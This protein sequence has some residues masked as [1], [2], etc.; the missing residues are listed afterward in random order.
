MSH[1]Y[2][3][4]PRRVVGTG[5]LRCKFGEVSI[6]WTSSVCLRKSGRS[7]AWCSTMATIFQFSA[8]RILAVNAFSHSLIASS[9]QWPIWAISRISS[10]SCDSKF[11]SSDLA[12]AGWARAIYLSTIGAYLKE[13]TSRW[14]SQ[15]NESIPCAADKGRTVGADSRCDHNKTAIRGTWRI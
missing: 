3:S 12:M 10:I 11:G 9:K 14:E 13:A 4:P 6:N 2:S 15:N 5:V 1:S 8:H 7:S